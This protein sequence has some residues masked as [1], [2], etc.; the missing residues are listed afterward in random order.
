M[1]FMIFKT[2]INPAEVELVR[3]S[4]NST[5]AI[6]EWTIDVDDIDRVLRVRATG[7]FGESDVMNLVSACGFHCEQLPD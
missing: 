3:S 6:S 2:N 1:E 7:N 4:F 5:P